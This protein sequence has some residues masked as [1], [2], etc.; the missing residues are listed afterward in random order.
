MPD[1]R[2]SCID[3]NIKFF[4]DTSRNNS[5][6]F[7]TRFI[8]IFHN[9]ENK[10]IEKTSPNPLIPRIPTANKLIKFIPI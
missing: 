1:K 6:K 2:L 4:F 9:I 8:G 3:C 7:F 10:A 5:Q